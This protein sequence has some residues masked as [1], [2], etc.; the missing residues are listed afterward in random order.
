LPPSDLYR[1]SRYA[2]VPPSDEFAVPFALAFTF[3]AEVADPNPIATAPAT[4][5]EATVLIIPY[6]HSLFDFLH[7]H[8]DAQ[9][10]S[11]PESGIGFE[12]SENA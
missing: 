8:P 10:L 11:T 6:L 3:A 4:A 2:A 5:R 7:S 9:A 12:Y 1:S